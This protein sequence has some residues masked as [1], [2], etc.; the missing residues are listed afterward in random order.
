MITFKGDFKGYKL[1][2]SFIRRH[3]TQ[4]PRRQDHPPNPHLQGTLSL[5]LFT[6][7]LGQY[8]RLAT[9]ITLIM[10]RHRCERA[11]PD[12][13]VHVTGTSVPGNTSLTGVP[14][15]PLRQE[16]TRGCRLCVAARYS[17]YYGEVCQGNVGF[18]RNVCWCDAATGDAEGMLVLL[19]QLSVSLSWKISL[20]NLVESSAWSWVC[21]ADAATV[22]LR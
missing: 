20:Q 4:Q 15:Q 3:V 19:S 9:C 22:Y 11:G 8:T 5:S 2:L 7:S 18:C 12:T 21:D 14:R 17:G 6:L 13:R 16:V 10:S 1:I